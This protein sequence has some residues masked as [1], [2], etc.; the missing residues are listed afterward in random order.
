[1]RAFGLLAA[2]FEPLD[3]GQ[4]VGLEL[5]ADDSGLALLVFRPG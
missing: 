3:I 4:P 1:V 2:P 5:S